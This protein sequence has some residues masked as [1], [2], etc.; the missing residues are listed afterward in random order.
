MDETEKKGGT[1]RLEVS[2]VQEISVGSD[3]SFDI[4][5]SGRE[6]IR[7]PGRNGESRKQPLIVNCY[8]WL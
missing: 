6:D 4:R 8:N 2:S 1:V 7:C 3:S 5:H